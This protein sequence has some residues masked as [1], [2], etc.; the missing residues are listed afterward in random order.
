MKRGLFHLVDSE[1]RIS[2]GNQRGEVGFEQ[3]RG[4]DFWVSLRVFTSGVSFSTRGRFCHLEIR[5]GIG[6]AGGQ[7]S[8]RSK[9]KWIRL[10]KQKFGVN[11]MLITTVMMPRMGFGVKVSAKDGASIP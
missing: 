11:E 3:P 10:Q 7:G 1:R 2:I 6:L 4:E 9:R 5:R 8:N